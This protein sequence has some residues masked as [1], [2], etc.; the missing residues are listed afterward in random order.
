MSKAEKKDNK[1]KR[2]DG[3]PRKKS[4]DGEPKSPM[5]KSHSK[6]LKNRKHNARAISPCK[7]FTMSSLSDGFLISHF[8][9][10]TVNHSNLINEKHANIVLALDND[11]I[12]AHKYIFDARCKKLLES[13]TIKKQKKGLV[14]Y[15]MKDME[16]SVMKHIITYLYSGMYMVKFDV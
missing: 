3:D 4:S 14:I 2:K 15:E 6:L 1:S 12:L 5:V 9:L 13:A 16:F 7:L 8:Y 11:Q 10:Y